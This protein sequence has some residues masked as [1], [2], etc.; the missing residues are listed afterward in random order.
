MTDNVK[1]RKLYE[2]TKTT[3]EKR[4]FIQVISTVRK[5]KCMFSFFRRNSWELLLLLPAYQV[6]WGKIG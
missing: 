3:G 1:Y 4:V 6:N 2:L 5:G